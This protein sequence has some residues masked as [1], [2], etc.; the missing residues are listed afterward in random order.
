MSRWLGYAHTSTDN[1]IYFLKAPT[2]SAIYWMQ[3]ISE[4]ELRHRGGEEKM[5]MAMSEQDAFCAIASPP[6]PNLGW[7]AN[8]VCICNG[9]RSSDISCDKRRH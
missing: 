5:A 2:K 7:L 1:N 3:S 4:P 9:P 6:T 8:N